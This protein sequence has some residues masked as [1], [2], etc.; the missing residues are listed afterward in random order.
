MRKSRFREEQINH[1]RVYRLFKA[2]GLAVRRK[3][4]AGSTRRIGMP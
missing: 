1:R 2:L 3:K 4:R